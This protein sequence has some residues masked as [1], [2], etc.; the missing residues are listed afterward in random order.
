MKFPGKIQ[1][2]V[3]PVYEQQFSN[4]QSLKPCKWLHCGSL[5]QI[6]LQCVVPYSKFLYFSDVPF[7]RFL[8]CHHGSLFHICYFATAPYYKFL[9]F[10]CGS[11]Y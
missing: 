9:L 3:Y 1:Q 7:S 5:F 8:L 6:L 11:W 4:I 10:Q 2:D